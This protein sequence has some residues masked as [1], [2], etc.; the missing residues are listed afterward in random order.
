MVPPHSGLG[1]EGPSCHVI[2]RGPGISK[3]RIKMTCDV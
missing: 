3:G 1:T 2:R